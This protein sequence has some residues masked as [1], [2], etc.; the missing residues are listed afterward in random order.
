MMNDV[1][2]KQFELLVELDTICRENNIPYCLFGY[3]AWQAW[4]KHEFLEGNTLPPE[5]AMLPN[6]VRKFIEVTEANLPD[7]R[8]VEYMGNNPNFD[9]Q[10]VRYG[11]KNTLDFAP[12]FAAFYENHGLHVT[13]HALCYGTEG[14]LST[15]MQR[16]MANDVEYKIRRAPFDVPHIA[17]HAAHRAWHKVSGGEKES[18]RY[19]DMLLDGG[20]KRDKARVLYKARGR[21][22]AT[23]PSFWFSDTIETELEGHV[24]PISSMYD[25]YF[26]RLYGDDWENAH[27]QVRNPDPELRIFD[28]NIPFAQWMERAGVAEHAQQYCKERVALNTKQEKTKQLS[29]K[30]GEYWRIV[31]RS[32]MRHKLWEEYMPQKQEIL[33]LVDAGNYDEASA[34]FAH[35]FEQLRVHKNRGLGLCFDP[36]LFRA[37]QR[38]LV[39]EGRFVY[40]QDL[41]SL[42]P[43]QHWQ[44][45]DLDLQEYLK[46]EPK[47]FAEATEEDLEEMRE[48]TSRYI[49]KG[50]YLYID[51]HKYGLGNPDMKLWVMRS[52]N[53][54]CINAVVMKYHDSMSIIADNSVVD[55]GFFAD[56]V[57]EYK[58]TMVSGELELIKQ[59][60]PL[61]ETE[62]EM[63]EGWVYD[64][65][66]YRLIESDINIERASLDDMAEAA[67]MISEEWPY[68]DRDDL[69]QQ[70]R[71][72]LQDGMARNFVVRD[73]GKIIAHIC[74]YA[75][76]QGIGITA[77]LVVDKDHRDVPY[78]TFMES[79]LVDSLRKSGL[80]AYTFVTS[81][82]RTRLFDAMGGSELSRYG[83]L[84]VDA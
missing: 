53:T 42:V 66:D 29:N 37:A 72:R 57:N 17:F 19:F 16:V 78:G 27:P 10:D 74:T 7:D 33:D 71:G 2:E 32:G 80:L 14:D 3:T 25:L 48:F 46:K 31:L 69:E 59:V 55:F 20:K 21:S 81:K 84:M 4:T 18:K 36:E 65:T 54:N 61:L 67:K 9:R 5:V 58:P 38:C 41:R 30:N 11:N 44:K 47:V 28:A 34:R 49:A 40:A 70:L 50:V 82:K 12:N 51:V 39:H 26:K 1:R 79:Y 52:A 35:Y 68:Y 60:V 45:L 43:K 23:Y 63:E 76:D 15:Q 24:F 77:G 56:L 75:E 22:S 64:I 73:N 83:K 8:F 6:A 62:Y 13:I